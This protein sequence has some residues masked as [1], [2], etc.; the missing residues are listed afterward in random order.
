MYKTWKCY[1]QYIY[2]A[3]RCFIKAENSNSVVYT[4]LNFDPTLYE[5]QKLCGRFMFCKLNR[6]VIKYILVSRDYINCKLINRKH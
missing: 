5:I 3:L 4:L 6:Q 1:S 2:N